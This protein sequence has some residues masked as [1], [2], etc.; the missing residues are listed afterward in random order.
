M[1]IVYC[2]ETIIIKIC[3]KG[4]YIVSIPLITSYF[5]FFKCI[6]RV[7]M[8]REKS[9]ENDFFPGQGKVREF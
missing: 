7:A 5:F 6:G 3:M 9:L 2:K 8:V 1:A 4:C